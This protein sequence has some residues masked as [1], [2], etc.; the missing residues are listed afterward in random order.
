MLIYLYVCGENV[1]V[2]CKHNGINSFD[3][4]F[5]CINTQKYVS[6]NTNILIIVVV[7]NV[8]KECFPAVDFFYCTFRIVHKKCFNKCCTIILKT[9]LVSLMV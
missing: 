4:F 2:E 3:S 1:E 9:K 7:K 5:L 6:F 8:F